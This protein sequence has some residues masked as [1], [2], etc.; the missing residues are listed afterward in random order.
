MATTDP[1]EPFDA[2][3]GFDLPRGEGS[4]PDARRLAIIPIPATTRTWRSGRRTWR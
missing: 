3:P 4:N 2:M 1:V